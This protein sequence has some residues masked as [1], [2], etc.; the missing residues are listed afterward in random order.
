L[1]NIYVIPLLTKTDAP[2]VVL[3]TVSPHNLHG[4]ICSV[5]I[6]STLFAR[7]NVLLLT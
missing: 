7:E 6:H 1:K 3:L 2:A 4:A 5:A